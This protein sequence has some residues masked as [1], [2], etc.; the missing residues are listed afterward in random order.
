MLRVANWPTNIRALK[1]GASIETPFFLVLNFKQCAKLLTLANFDLKVQALTLILDSVSGSPRSFFLDTKAY[2]AVT[3]T[4][5][6]AF[7]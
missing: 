2:R 1:K 5:S 7:V 4:N 6:K 3:Q